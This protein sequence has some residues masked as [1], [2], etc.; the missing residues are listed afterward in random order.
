MREPCAS[1]Q[2]RRIGTDLSCTCGARIVAETQEA[3]R[4]FVRVHEGCPDVELD[5]V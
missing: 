5:C 3:F 2:P 4:E 1:E